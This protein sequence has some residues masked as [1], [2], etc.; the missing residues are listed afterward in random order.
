MIVAHWKHI[1]ERGRRVTGWDGFWWII[2]MVGVLIISG[3]LSWRYWGDL[4][5]TQDSL[6]TTIRNLGLV[7][8]GIEAILLAA[9][10]SIVAQRQAAAAQRQA[11]TS[12]QGLLN[13]R[14]QREA[15]MLGSEVLSV[16]IGG[17]YAL[18]RLAAEH[19]EQYHI[20]VMELLCAFAR[21]PTKRGTEGEAT[22]MHSENDQW[23][24]EPTIR[25][26]VQ[27]V[28]TAISYR[29]RARLQYEWATDNFRLDLRGAYL[30]E[31]DLHGANLSGAI[32]SRADLTLAEISG[33]MLDNSDLRGANLDSAR[34]SQANLLG[35]N[36]VNT[37]LTGA[38]LTRA[39][40]TNADLN[41][42]SLIEADLSEAT[43]HHA[44]LTRAI[45]TAVNVS[46]AKLTESRFAH[47]NLRYADFSGAD[48][49]LSSLQEADLSGASIERAARTDRGVPRIQ[50]DG[51]VRVTQVQLDEAVADADDPPSIARGNVDIETGEPLVWH[52]QERTGVGSEPPV[53]IIP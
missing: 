27:A 21:N 2:G 1:R 7:V 16:R 17:V 3:G 9:W 37:N 45:L 22:E 18:D 5:G 12:Q 42:A 39:D 20:Q 8:G 44:N 48:L 43:V 34:L 49:S 19:P 38:D 52:G 36:M 32:L 14:Y 50:Q 11:D 13:E 41:R 28:L 4:H 40:L 15:E 29:S 46:R 24:S 53:S 35:A 26:D 6:S 47:A 23:F 30:R 31:A 51:F 33:V 25:E 10:R